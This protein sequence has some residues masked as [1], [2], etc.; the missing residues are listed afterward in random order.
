MP[1]GSHIYAISSEMNMAAIYEYSP[2]QHAFPH[3]KFVL[4]CC[5]NSPYI[6]VLDQES[7]SHH[8]NSSPSIC[9]IFI[10]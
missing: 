9:F 8:P 1:H 3:W 2:S 5:S 7:D 6:D 10:T 4:C